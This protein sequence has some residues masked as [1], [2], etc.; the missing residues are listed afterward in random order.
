MN[1]KQKELMEQVIQ[2]MRKIYP[3]FTMWVRGEHGT[4]VD[5]NILVPDDEDQDWEL[6]EILAHKLTNILVESGYHFNCF[7]YTESEMKQSA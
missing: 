3:P 7:P 2:D 5:V 6:S 1:R 4:S